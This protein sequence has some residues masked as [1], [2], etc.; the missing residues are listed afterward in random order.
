MNL[1]LPFS[2]KARFCFWDCAELA[3]EA[4]YG[5]EDGEERGKTI[6]EGQDYEVEHRISAPVG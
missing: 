4:L 2:P 5:G 3:G 1:I 6:A